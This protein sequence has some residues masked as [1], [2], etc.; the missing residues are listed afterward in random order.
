MGK[1]NAGTLQLAGIKASGEHWDASLNGGAGGVATTGAYILPP[2]G[3]GVTLTFAADGTFTV[4]PPPANPPIDRSA[5]PPQ[6]MSPPYQYQSGH[7]IT[8]DGW[9][10]TLQGTPKAGDSVTVG[11]AKDPQYGDWYTRNASNAG[12][13]RTLRDKKM[14]DESTLSDGYAGLM[15]TVGTRA[16]SAQYAAKLSDSIANNLEADRSAISGVN[17]DEEA[18]KLIQYQ[19]AYQASA[20][21]LQIA[22]NIFDN[23]IQTMGR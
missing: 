23:L 11:D 20:K 9:E 21:L 14:F 17:L 13:L 1:S 15:A 7:A 8:I 12:A 3:S 10:I 5:T 18:A 4:N 22:Q 6:E 16:Q 2:T 19:Q